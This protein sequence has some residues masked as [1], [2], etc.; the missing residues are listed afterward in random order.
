MWANEN[1]TRR[2][3][4]SDDQILLSQDYRREDEADLIAEFA[5]HFADERYI[6]I[7]GRPVLMVYRARMIPDTVATVSRWRRLFQAIH[8][9]DPLFIMA[10]SFG[11]TDPRSYGMDAAV[12][13]PPHKLT[14][15]VPMVTDTL[16]V[17]DPGFDAEVYDYAAIARASVAEPVPAFP[18][19][20]TVVPSWDNDPRRQG[21]G[22]I[23]H[24]ATPAL[25]QAW[26]E[27]LIRFAR[28][29]PVEGE[30]IVCINAWNEWA[31]GATLEPDVHWGGAF[32]NATARAVT[33]LP[34]TGA[35]TRLLLIGHDGLAHGA[36][37]LLLR[38]GQALRAA[39]GVE[40][41]FI[42]LAGGALE[43]PVPG[44][45][46]DADR[47]RPRPA[48]QVDPG[49]PGDGLQCGDRQ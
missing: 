33:G 48:R 35:R 26:L 17:L 6:R 5:R 16:Q 34:A 4:G 41:A 23:L 32:L 9:E 25:Y 28:R 40:I 18:L 29:H 49:G 3:D 13:F 2:W 38:L 20:K 12:E 37:I 15:K 1:W 45:G 19:I 31:E 22:T 39:H 47:R 21:K 14:S 46:A 30:A 42:L 24:G 43:A 27:D 11:D 7:A 36:Q 44:G 8:G 10:Q